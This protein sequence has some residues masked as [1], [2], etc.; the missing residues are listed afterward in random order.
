MPSGHV[1]VFARRERRRLPLDA[2]ALSRKRYAVR[3]FRSQLTHD[4]STNAG[5]ILRDT[6]L[7]RASRSFEVMFS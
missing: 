6:M 1:G 7:A 3:A 5:P 2:D 4:E